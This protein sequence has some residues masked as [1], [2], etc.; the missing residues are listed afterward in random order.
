M[1][2]PLVLVAIILGIIFL[3]LA[4]IYFMEQAKSLPGFLPGYEA[5]V[6]TRH[7]KHGIGALVLGLACFAFA[8]FQ[9]GSKK[10]KDTNPPTIAQ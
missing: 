1:N 10:S 5:N 6:A 8:W 2:K 4:G 9:S 3:I 7:Y